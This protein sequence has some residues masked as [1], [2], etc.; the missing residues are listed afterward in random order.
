MNFHIW[1]LII[2]I[3]ARKYCSPCALNDLVRGCELCIHVSCFNGLDPPLSK[4]RYANAYGRLT[5]RWFVLASSTDLK[6]TFHF[7]P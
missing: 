6:V 2:V 4:E 7:T 5:R 1:K 3:G